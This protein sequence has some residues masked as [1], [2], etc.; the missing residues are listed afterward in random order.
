MHLVDGVWK[1]VSEYKWSL[2]MVLYKYFTRERLIHPMKVPSLSDKECVS[3]VCAGRG[4]LWVRQL[5]QRMRPCCY[6]FL[7]YMRI[8]HPHSVSMTACKCDDLE[9]RLT[10]PPYLHYRHLD[11]TF[12]LGGAFGLCTAYTLCGDYR[13]MLL[14]KTKLPNW[15]LPTRVGDQSAKLNFHRIFGYVLVYLVLNSICPTLKDVEQQGLRRL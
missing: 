13:Y 9:H 5:L 3:E 10:Q 14:A 11:W 2:K 8:L 6:H 4:Y 1:R 12:K 15:N 7:V